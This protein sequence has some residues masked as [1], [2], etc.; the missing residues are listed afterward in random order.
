[1]TSGDAGFV[2]EVDPGAD[3]EKDKQNPEEEYASG[4]V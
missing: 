4:P 2:P 3:K 1:M